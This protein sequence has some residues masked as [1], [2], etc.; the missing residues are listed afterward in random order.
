MYEKK[1]SNSPLLDEDCLRVEKRVYRIYSDAKEIL[2]EGGAK[3]D[4]DTVL[5]TEDPKSKLA[6]VM[7]A[8][9]VYLNFVGLI[10]SLD[11]NEAIETSYYM[12]ELDYWNFMM[13]LF[14]EVP[15]LEYHPARVGN[16]L[17]DLRSGLKSSLGGK[18][19]KR[20]ATFNW[21]D[22]FQIADTLTEENSELENNVSDLARKIE[23]SLRKNNKDSPSFNTLRTKLRKKS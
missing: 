1:K 21:E 3:F 2:T 11:K 4:D 17:S 15:E 13:V 5:M 7:I 14:G 20:T 9:L 12:S 18:K 6:V 16:F 22:I 10:I 19:G 8:H 23:K